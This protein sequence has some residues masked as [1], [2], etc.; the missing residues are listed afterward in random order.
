MY[1]IFSVGDAS[2]SFDLT[3]GD[4]NP[5]STFNAEESMIEH[6]GMKSSTQDKDNDRYY[7]SCA[8]DFTGGWWYNACYW[9][10]PTGTY[11]L[12]GEV[13]PRGVAFLRQRMAVIGCV[14]PSKKCSSESDRFKV[15]YRKEDE[16]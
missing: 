15:H 13:D 6:N 4:K 8:W 11:L 14:T 1:L 9:A 7:R 16:F 10:H 2:G 3:V 5:Q 12:N